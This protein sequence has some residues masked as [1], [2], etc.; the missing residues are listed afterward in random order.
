M[1]FLRLKKYNII[2]RLCD[3]LH[4]MAKYKRRGKYAKIKRKLETI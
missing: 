1:A 2:D 4:Y 3:L